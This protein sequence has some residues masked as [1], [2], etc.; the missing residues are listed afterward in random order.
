MDCRLQRPSRQRAAIGPRTSPE[1]ELLAR[2][3]LDQRQIGFRIGADNLGRIGGAIL[4]SNLDRFGMIDDMIVG[5]RIT[6]RGDEEAGAHAGDSSMSERR[7]LR[8]LRQPKLPKELLQRGARLK[9]KN[10]P[11]SDLQ[12]PRSALA[13]ILTRTEMTAGLTLATRSAKLAGC[14]GAPA[15]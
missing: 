9:W 6:V 4:G 2:I 8:R 10:S 1:G 13:I 15:T 12:S 14:P 5:Y 3:D 7:R 11:R